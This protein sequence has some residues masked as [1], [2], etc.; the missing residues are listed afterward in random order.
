MVPQLALTRLAG[1]FAEKQWGAITHLAIKAFS[2]KYKINLQEAEKTEA[3]QYTS[4][5]EFFIR[6]LKAEARPIHADQSAV[7]LPADGCISELGDITNG[8]LFQAKGH[9][10]SLSDL[11]AEDKKSAEAFENGKF[12]TTYLSPRDYHRVH[13]PCD[14][15]LRKMVYVPGDLFSVN[16]FLAQHIPNLF[17]RNERVICYFD[18]PFGAMVQILV[19][20]TITAS[21]STVWAGVI[22]PPRNGKVQQWEYPQD[23][24]SAVQLKKGEEMGAFRLG[25]TVINL[26]QADKIAFLPTLT[27]ASAV[28]MGQAMT[29]STATQDSAA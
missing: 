16:P 6:P 14:G 24:A 10:F 8:Q 19:G 3:N 26:F 4:F 13:M 25:S 28:N 17:A 20:A 9:F 21:I 23:G 18:T 11:L 7:C 22:N 5:N 2:A 29:V 1:W 27:A 12:I 15:V